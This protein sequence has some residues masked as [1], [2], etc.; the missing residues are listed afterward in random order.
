MD[1]KKESKVKEVVH[2]ICKKQVASRKYVEVGTKNLKNEV[3]FLIPS[4][5]EEEVKK[6][7]RSW[8]LYEPGFFVQEV[9]TYTD[10]LNRFGVCEPFTPS[11]KILEIDASTNTQ[12]TI[13]Y[14]ENLGG[15]TE[16]IYYDRY[17]N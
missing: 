12:S 1:D 17:V 5:T 15:V 4:L 10:E 2:K 7:H 3:V 9:T 6:Q 13:G 14:V 11:N 8:K 16:I